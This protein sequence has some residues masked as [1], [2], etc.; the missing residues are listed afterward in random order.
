MSGLYLSN[1]LAYDSVSVKL[2]N[3]HE[4]ANSAGLAVTIS[5]ETSNAMLYLNGSC[6]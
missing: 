5:L 3:S 2:K 4:S 6:L 1:A